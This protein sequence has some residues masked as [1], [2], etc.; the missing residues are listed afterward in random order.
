MAYTRN[1]TATA[2]ICN[3]IID[4]TR[5]WDPIELKKENI[6][7]AINRD[8]S[9][10]T[11]MEDDPTDFGDERLICAIDGS[12]IPGDGFGSRMD[13]ETEHLIARLNAQ[14]DY[15][16][17]N[18]E[19]CD[20]DVEI[21]GNEEEETEM[22]H[23][24][25][26]S[27]TQSTTQATQNAPRKR[28]LTS[29][30]WKDIVSVGVEDDGKERG[31]CIHCGTKLVINTKTHGT[32]SLIRHLE[33]CPKKPKNEDRPPYDHQINRE[34][35]SE[36]I[37][38]HDLP[39]RYPEYEKVRA[40]DKYLNPEC[41][42][43][44]RQTAAADVYRKYEM[45][46]VKL[47]EVLANQRA[48]VCF[49][50]DLWTARGTVMSYICLTAH[51]I[52]ENWH[53]NSKIL[54]FCELKSPHTGEEISN[55]ILE[56]L[57]EWGLEKKVF[58]ITLDNATNN[59][60]M[61]NILKGQ[62]QMISGSGLLC[63]GKFMHVRCCAHILNLI[64]KK[65]LDLAKDVLHNI[66]ESVIYVKASSKR[67]DAFAACV[68]RVKIKSGAGLSQDVPTRWNSTYEMLVRALKF[69]E[70]FVSLKWFDNNYKTLPSDDEWNRGEKICELLKPFSDITTH[71]SGSKYPTSNVYFTQVWRI[72]LLLRKFASCDDEDVAK[73]AQDMQIMFTKYWEDYSL[74]LAMGA[75]LDPRMKLQMLEVAYERVD[76]T[77]SASK[78][79]K[80]KDNLEM[81][82]EDYKAK[83]RT[84][85]SS[86]SNVA[87]VVY[88]ACVAYVA[89]VAYVVY[90]A[91][92]ASFL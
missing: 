13:L 85:S 22:L 33:K 24:T 67:R 87:F 58:S 45:E 8:E 65:G 19:D 66:R 4:P 26:Q 2:R 48:R 55:K 1:S 3:W 60:S 91:C 89:Y 15:M 75:V 11:G 25:D 90:V 6:E 46:K 50:S 78:I 34:M 53:L 30:V 63:D 9:K 32:K 69:K 73:L 42:P 36:I 20:I 88:V 31:K 41:Q 76:P 74:I 23:R 57:K 52:D 83:S 18:E 79:K 72:E 5:S 51:Y 16:D 28:K 59:N 40:R 68:E 77:T 7:L 14:S 80:L 39:F 43:I 54:Q 70:A 92:V 17:M 38:Y 21:D 27:E 35:T 29:K 10:A 62:L 56:C 71:F 37:I 81:L 49:T 61:L 44:C 12:V 82:Y 86:I 84:C 47:K 64:V